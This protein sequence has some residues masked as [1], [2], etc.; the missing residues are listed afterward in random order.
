MCKPETRLTGGG[1]EPGFTSIYQMMQTVS[2]CNRFKRVAC[3]VEVLCHF[4]DVGHYFFNGAEK[5]SQ[6]FQKTIYPFP[7]PYPSPYP[8]PDPD[9][10]PS[11][12]TVFTV[13]ILG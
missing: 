5:K 4:R 8:Y 12:D 3:I 1:S 7:D 2:F 13:S 9:P 11:C 10:D 6:P